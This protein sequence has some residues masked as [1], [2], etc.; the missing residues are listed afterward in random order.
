[1]KHPPYIQFLQGAII[2][3]AFLAIWQAA[4]TWEW[5]PPSIIASPTDSLANMGSLISDCANEGFFHCEIVRHTLNSLGRLLMG[6][7]MGCSV[8][9]VVGMLIG[10]FKWIARTIEPF[11]LLLI[12]VPAIAWIPVLIIFFGYEDL[13]KIVLI[14]I[15][16]AT[17]LFL[18]TS[19]AVKN[20]NRD[21]LELAHVCRKSDRSIL[22]QIIFPAT[23]PTIFANMRVAMALS[24]TLLLA[25]EMISGSNGLGWW[26]EDSRKFLRPEDMI[27]SMLIIGLLGKL[28]DWLIVK[29]GRYFNRWQLSIADMK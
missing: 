19:F 27:C 23:L 8:G 12:P 24:W 26:I 15:G 5:I 18:A 1:M 6:F 11:L 2:P 28:S 20:M 29:A 14:A 9:I 13:S 25:A 16:S 3:L 17:T 10:Y 7:L 22:K 21:L 4:V